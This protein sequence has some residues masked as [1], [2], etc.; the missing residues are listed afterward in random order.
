[1]LLRIL[2]I[3]LPLVLVYFLFFSDHSLTSSFSSFFRRRREN[4]HRAREAFEHAVRRR[5]R[6]VLQEALALHGPELTK[7][8]RS[9]LEEMKSDCILDE[10]SFN[11]RKR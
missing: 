3:G 8:E 2:E 4:R 9:I 7:Y 1:M 10:E 6:V 11:V 5:T